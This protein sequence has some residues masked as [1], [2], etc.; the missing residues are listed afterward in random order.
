MTKLNLLR[1]L[2]VKCSTAHMHCDWTVVT[3]YFGLEF[4]KF[5]FELNQM[6]MEYSRFSSSQMI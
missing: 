5:D 2:L 1:Y 4:A 3:F 6:Q